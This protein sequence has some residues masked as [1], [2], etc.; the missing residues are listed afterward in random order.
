MLVEGR[1]PVLET[2]KSEHKVTTIFLQNRMPVSEKIKKLLSKAHKKGVRI[3][4]MSS[5]KLDKLSQTQ[6]HQGVIAIVQH[7]TQTLSETLDNLREKNK[8]PFLVFLNDVIYQQNLGAI[9][10]SAECAGCN[11]VIIPRNTTLTP[12]A[13]RS[14]M[15]ATEHIP[16]IQESIF[17]ALKIL[18]DDGIPIIGLEADGTSTIYEENLTG[19]ITFIIGGEDKGITRSVL[20]KCDKV[21][22][23]PLYGKINSLN[24]SN[25]AAVVLFEKVR[26]ELAKSGN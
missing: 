15:G 8:D 20:N 2:L 14:S 1:N 24:M 17:N 23:I 18:K 26:Q 21:L 3:R 13:I 19:P 22:K 4:K 11:G 12:E 9:I 7:K 10:R 25:S 6:N 16:I 5:N